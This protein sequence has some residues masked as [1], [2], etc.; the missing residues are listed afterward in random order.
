MLSSCHFLAPRKLAERPSGLAPD[1]VTKN[2]S[3]VGEL[4]RDSRPPRV[5]G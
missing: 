3:F 4:R 2:V 1:D 5:G